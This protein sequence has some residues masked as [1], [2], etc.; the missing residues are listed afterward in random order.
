M[1]V[2]SDYRVEGMSAAQVKEL[3]RALGVAADGAWGKVS[4]AALDAAYGRN[5]DPYGAYTGA[6]PQTY[7]AASVAGAA[8]GGSTG[9]TYRDESG[10]A[11]TSYGALLRNDGF[12]YP[13]GAKISPNGMYY[14]TGSG[15]QFAASGSS[16]AGLA[17]GSAVPGFERIPIGTQ[18]GAAGGSEGTGQDGGAQDANTDADAWQGYFDRELKRYVEELYTGYFD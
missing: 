2:R 8:L 6:E 9:G 10:N 13:A 17:P 12:E 5:A 16:V 11:Y 1:A 15:W 18:A 14:D 4:Q 7:G 3:Q